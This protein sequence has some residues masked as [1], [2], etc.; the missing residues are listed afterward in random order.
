MPEIIS[1][2]VVCRAGEGD[3]AISN[4]IGSTIS[5]NVF[6]IGLP[7]L[8]KLIVNMVTLQTFAPITIYS[9]GKPEILPILNFC[10][11]LCSGAHRKGGGISPETEKFVENAFILLAA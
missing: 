5:N 3:M 1:S 11:N 8:L 4:A 10:L 2:A 7:W 9:E 6:G